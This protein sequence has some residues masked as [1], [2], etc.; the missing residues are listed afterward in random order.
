[1]SLNW[2]EVKFM[3]ELVRS[4]VYV[5]NGQ[6]YISDENLSALFLRDGVCVHMWMGGG[7]ASVHMCVCDLCMY[8][9][10]C[11]CVCACACT[12]KSGFPCAV[13]VCTERHKLQT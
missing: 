8:T 6:R 5:Q 1:M 11:V 10:V 2:S 7:E 9:C 4:K 13:T 3:F 12:S